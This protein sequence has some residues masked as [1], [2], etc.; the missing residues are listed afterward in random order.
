[1]ARIW[2][3]ELA[4]H[5]G[6]PVELAGGLHRFRQLSHVS[7]MILRDGKGMAQVVVDDPTQIAALAHLPTET[8]LRVSGMVVLVAAAPGGVEVHG[9]QV[10]VVSVPVESPPFDLFRP[11]LKAQLP[12]ILDH[13]DVALR[14]PRLRAV[15]RVAAASAAGYRHTLH[16]RDFVEIF[17]PK[18]VASAT[19]G[20]ANVFRWTT[21]AARRFWRRARSSTSRSWSARTSACSKSARCSACRHGGR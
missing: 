3:T 19:E 15:H 16:E 21:L 17:T 6:Q 11:V 18:L 2:S 7:F 20:G 14:H 9:P 1:M 4:A 13:A 12:T 10:E 8:V 5:I